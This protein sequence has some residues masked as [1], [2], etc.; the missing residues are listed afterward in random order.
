MHMCVLRASSSRI[1]FTTDM[2]SGTKYGESPKPGRHA[3]L[4]AWSAAS[5]RDSTSNMRAELTTPTMLSTRSSYTG[6]RLY[7]CSRYDARRS[8]SVALLSTPTT[9]TRG[10]MTSRTGVSPISSTF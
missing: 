3:T 1:S 8:E 4:A 2:L 6:T 5:S 7:L 10:V 9:R